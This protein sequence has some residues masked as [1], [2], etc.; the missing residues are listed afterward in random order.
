MK[1]IRSQGCS[2]RRAKLLVNCKK[3]AVYLI[4]FLL[5]WPDSSSILLPYE[6]AQSALETLSPQAVALLAVRR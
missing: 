5:Y 3:G 4:F 2:V 1:E 6:E